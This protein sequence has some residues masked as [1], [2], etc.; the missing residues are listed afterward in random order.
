MSSASQDLEALV[1]PG[2]R[3]SPNRT[4]TIPRRKLR[5]LVQ[6]LA[7]SVAIL[8]NDIEIDEVTQPSDEVDDEGEAGGRG[9]SKLQGIAVPQPDDEVDAASPGVEIE[10]VDASIIGSD[11]REGGSLHDWGQD[12]ASP[13]EVALLRV[14]N[15]KAFEGSYSISLGNGDFAEGYR[16]PG[17][18]RCE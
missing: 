2:A 4:V 16:A 17:L 12:I 5:K 6:M 13:E 18:G 3:P 14:E 1:E 7:Y 10:G 11:D 15:L 9:R 8:Q